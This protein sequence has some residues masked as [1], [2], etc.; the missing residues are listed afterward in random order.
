MSNIQTKNTSNL[1][2][3]T[4]Y[5]LTPSDSVI[6]SNQSKLRN[7]IFKKVFKENI[8]YS[9][10]IYV[11][12]I[13][14]AR[15]NGYE[16]REVVNKAYNEFMNRIKNNEDMDYYEEIDLINIIYLEVFYSFKTAFELKNSIKISDY[17]FVVILSKNKNL[18]K[19]F[20][21]AFK[22]HLKRI[23]VY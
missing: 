22:K 9:F 20:I 13:M 7:K 19:K 10:G 21:S 3:Y 14:Y 18:I 15:E 12:I 4:S 5:N 8:S 17:I 16:V 23:A 2:D 11:Y 6:I 1:T